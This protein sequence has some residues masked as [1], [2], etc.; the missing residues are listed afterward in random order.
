[1]CLKTLF[2]LNEGDFFYFMFP[3]RDNRLFVVVSFEM[4]GVRCRNV[5]TDEINYYS[6]SAFV[7]PSL[8]G[9]R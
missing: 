7:C 9:S 6:Y 2:N 3:L 1:M 8:I 5:D 4:D